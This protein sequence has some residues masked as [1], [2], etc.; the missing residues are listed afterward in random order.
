[1]LNE[2]A[3]LLLLNHYRNK[4]GVWLTD[5]QKIPSLVVHASTTNGTSGTGSYRKC[6]V[7]W[8]FNHLENR[9]IVENS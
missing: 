9:F 3:T 1:M 8:W 4:N 5:Y 7:Y 6:K 2:L